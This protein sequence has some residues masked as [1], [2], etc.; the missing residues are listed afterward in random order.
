MPDRR[1][2]RPAPRRFETADEPAGAGRS[3]VAPASRRRVA[4]FTLFEV[5]IAASIVSV[6]ALAVL[7]PYGHAT[8][9]QRIDVLRANAANLAAQQMERLT[10]LD[11]ATLLDRYADGGGRSFE[12]VDGSRMTGPDLADYTLTIRT[13]ELVIALAGESE[14]EAARF[15]RAVVT[16]DHPDVEPVR[17]ARLFARE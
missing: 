13:A 7:I 6:A 5:L 3:P 12:H 15:C 4:G 9:A 1:S 8:T 2:A 16:V 10:T 14:E 17:F 11:Y